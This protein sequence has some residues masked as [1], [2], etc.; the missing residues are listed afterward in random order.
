MSDADSR[1]ND[2]ADRAEAGA[3]IIEQV[4]NGGD[5]VEVP[6]A[7]GPRPSLAKWFADRYAEFYAWAALILA[8]CLEALGLAQAVLADTVAAKAAAESA[9]AGAVAA[10]DAAL[11][12]RGL[13]QTTAQGIGQGVAGIA[14]LVAGSGGTNGTFALAFS[15]GTQIIAPRGY[16]VVAGGVVTQ[17]V[18]TYA[19][20]YSAGTPALS[21]A[22]SAGLT[23]ASA[24]AVMGANTPVD[25]YFS[26]PVAGSN[27]SLI[28]YKVTTGPAATEIT[29]YPSSAKVTALADS[30]DDIVEQRGIIGTFPA[31]SNASFGTYTF[32]SPITKTGTGI[33]Y[34][35]QAKLTGT[36]YVQIAERAGDVNTIISERLIN[37]TAGEGSVYFPDLAYAAGQYVGVRA[38]PAGAVA[39]IGGTDPDGGWWFTSSPIAAGGNYTDAT[40]TTNTKI[41]HR[42]E[43]MDQVVT[44]P[45]FTALEDAITGI[46]GDDDAAT[47]N[48]H[49]VIGESHAAG[50]PTTLS[51]VAVPVGR[52]Y[53]YRRATTSLGHLQDPTGN[54]ATAIAGSGRGSM[55]PAFGS[56]ILRQTNN[57]QGAIIVN[58]GD[59]GTT[60]V[61]Q[62]A[63]GGLSWLQ[64]VTDYGNALTAIQAAGLIIGGRSISVILGSND[65][66]VGTTKAAFKAAVLDIITRART[67]VGA[68]SDVPVVLM[69]TGSYA[70][71]SYAA[72]V[73]YIQE[74][75][76]EIVNETANV[77][78]GYSAKFAVA[79]GQM[80]DNVHMTQA[81]NDVCGASLAV[82]AFTHGAGV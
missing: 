19:G 66:A 71:N 24:T 14:S 29:R 68:G 18:I 33:R 59:G 36:I 38:T 81:Y 82:P 50:V 10:R 79:R 4:A 78:M 7:S 65:A 60:A 63:S 76:R 16:F 74:A 80:I 67:L 35:Y 32:A 45:R 11:L 1:L 70:D 41:V 73:A 49:F 40:L 44:G 27:D 8:D 20:H 46:V 57:L 21:F 77:Y 26:V 30:L 75:Q 47:F 39:A 3:D 62:W 22:A 48:L 52:G 15:G 58:S 28:L 56:Q 43:L 51:P 23:G 64:A 12:S 13:W 55:F 69:Q 53:C 37:V 42:F 54:S 34:H 72:A 6:T 5:A 9:Q 17:V 31:G 25:A 61:G 2:A